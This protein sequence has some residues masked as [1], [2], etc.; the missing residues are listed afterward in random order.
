MITSVAVGV[1]DPARE[2]TCASAQ[3]ST[4]IQKLA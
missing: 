4:R 2:P 3:E 1:G